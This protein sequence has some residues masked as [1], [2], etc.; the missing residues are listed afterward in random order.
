MYGWINFRRL[1]QMQKL[2]CTLGCQQKLQ[3]LAQV[4]ITLGLNW[5]KP[6]D[7]RAATGLNPQIKDST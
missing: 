2:H 5:F 1:K 3:V 4:V 6:S 7:A